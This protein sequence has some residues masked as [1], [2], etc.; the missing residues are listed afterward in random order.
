[1]INTADF[2]RSTNLQ[3]DTVSGNLN[4]AG[5]INTGGVSNLGSIDDLLIS[6]GSD[7]QTIIT[8]GSGDLSWGSLGPTIGTPV[9]ASGS[10]TITFSDVPS[11]VKRIS[12]SGAGL[13]LSTLAT[14]YL[15]I[16]GA[17]TPSGSIGVVSSLASDGASG[18]IRYST[19]TNVGL[20]ILLSANSFSFFANL[21][22]LDSSSN[23]WITQSQ[24]SDFYA[25]AYRW[26]TGYVTLNSIA[27][28]VGIY[29][30]S[31]TFTAGT[32]N[33]MYHK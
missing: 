32:V 16:S 30:S 15:R 6:G 33:V 17:G 14:V 26:T 25:T 11:N 9:L 28:S 27:T 22:L 1:V 19:G 2:E 5:G 4:I 10:S 24:N 12:I 8:N 18:S 29:T 7:G 23:L 13:T 20:P 3:V 21:Y 31:G